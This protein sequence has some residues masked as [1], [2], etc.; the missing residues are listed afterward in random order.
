MRLLLLAAVLAAT[1]CGPR[2]VTVRVTVPDLAGIETP[3]RGLQ[4]VFLPYDRDSIVRGFEAKAATPRPHTREL[5][6]L[7]REFRPAYF[8]F[9]RLALVTERLRRERDSLLGSQ[10]SSPPP[11]ADSRRVAVTDSLE[12]LL[13]LEKAANEELARVR[14]RVGPLID[15]YR[16]DV[17]KWERGTFRDYETTVRRLGERSFANPVADTTDG[18]GW[19]TI[20]LTNG[21]WWAT[22]RSIDPG[23]PH[24]EWYWNVPITGDTVALSSRT[25]LHRPRY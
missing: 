19:A 23:D 20:E 13:P 7:Y 15:R 2:R 17:M 8:T 21:R 6:S 16:A 9:I 24:A 12:R 1:G 5:D 25:G 11:P 14:Q 10:G 18:L 4:V 3:V 22:S